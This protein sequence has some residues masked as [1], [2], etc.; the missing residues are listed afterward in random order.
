MSNTYTLNYLTTTELDS[1]ENKSK[2]FVERTRIEPV[3]QEN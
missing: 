3:S 1:C 2:Q